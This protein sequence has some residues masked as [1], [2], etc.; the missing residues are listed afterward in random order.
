MQER[1]LNKRPTYAMQETKN[2][3]SSNYYPVT[4]AIVMRDH[5]NDSYKQV[6]VMIDR[7]RGGAADLTE[8][9]TIELMHNRRIL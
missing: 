9:A 2:N 1:Q 3:I 7:A 6:T 4:S 5:S 8:H